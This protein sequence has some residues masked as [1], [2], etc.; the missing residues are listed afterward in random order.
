[1]TQLTTHFSLREL[2]H[3]ATA[4]RLNINNEPSKLIL[5][6]L[7]NTAEK[8]ETVRRLLGGQPIFVTSG[9]RSPTL[10]AAIGG[11]KN[12]AHKSGYAVDFKVS[13]MS[14]KDTVEKIRASGIKYDQLINEYDRWVHIS[15]DPRMRQQTL[16]IG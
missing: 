1:M 10:N 4:Q 3:S 5:E 12:S 15:F 11:A 16:K 14:V 13:F 8:M 7:K 2:A 6:R 9:Y